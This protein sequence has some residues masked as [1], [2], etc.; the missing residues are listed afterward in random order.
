MDKL[1]DTTVKELPDTT[2][3]Y[4]HVTMDKQHSDTNY[5]GQTASVYNGQT[6]SAYNGQTAF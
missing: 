6:I 1:P 5:N 3:I 4:N 2:S